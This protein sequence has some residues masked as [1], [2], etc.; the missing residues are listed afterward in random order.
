MEGGKIMFWKLLTICLYILSPI[1]IYFVYILWWEDWGQFMFNR[2]I[3]KKGRRRI[4]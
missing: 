1:A 3:I 2:I 4:E